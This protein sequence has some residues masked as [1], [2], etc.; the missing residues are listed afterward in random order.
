MQTA[1]DIQYASRH[2][3][4]NRARG[5]SVQF[6]SSGRAANPYTACDYLFNLLSAVPR[7]LSLTLRHGQVPQSSAAEGIVGFVNG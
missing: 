6:V 7:I 3:P 1:D 5:K 2:Q 4:R